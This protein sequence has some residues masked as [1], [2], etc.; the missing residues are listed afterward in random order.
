MA[1]KKSQLYSSLWQSCDELRGGMDASQYKDYIL[2]LLFVKYVSDIHKIVDV[3]N[4]QVERP[5][6]SR[7]VPVSEIADPANDYN[8][9]I[10]RYVD[11]S[12]PEDLHDLE[13]HLRGGI[14]NRDIDD[15]Q[16]YWADVMQDDVYLIAADGWMEAAK[17]RGVIDDKEKKIKETPDLVVKKKKYKLDLIPPALIVARYFADE[18]AEIEVL[19]AN[20]EEAARELEEFTE[21]HAVE[22]GLLEG[23]MNDQGKVTRGGVKERLE[24]IEDEAESDD[25]RAALARCLALMDAEAEAKRAVRDAQEKLD[26]GTLAKYGDLSEDAIKTLAVDDKWFT[27]IQ[28]AVDGEVQRITQRLAE[29]VKEL[30]ERYTSPVPELVDQVETLSAKADEHLKQMGFE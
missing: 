25:E 9:N 30:E 18:Q 16:D 2:T 20:H 5:R 22:E 7:M 29:R 14:P 8:L 23:A 10:P 27:S 11:S 28:T 21:E 1:L 6:Y 13:A 12:E 17:P 26:A 15:L 19:E 24:A 4:R 3:F